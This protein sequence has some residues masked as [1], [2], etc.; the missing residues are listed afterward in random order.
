M[1][2]IVTLL[3]IAILLFSGC[4]TQFKNGAFGG[5]PG[6]DRPVTP[7][8]LTILLEIK[9]SETE[10]LPSIAVHNIIISKGYLKETEIKDSPLDDNG[11]IVQCVD[12][13]DNVL[14]QE[15][16]SNP[17]R[18]RYETAGE[19]GQLFTHQIELESDVFPFRIRKTPK[20]H[21]LKIFIN[22]DQKQ[23]LLKHLVL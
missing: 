20:V 13:E 21:A 18:K 10:K 12:S 11:L 1:D 9:N 23:I 5:I 7:E 3:A 6:T 16:M 8:I 4:K 19:D 14:K 17:L 22:R 15:I 2:R